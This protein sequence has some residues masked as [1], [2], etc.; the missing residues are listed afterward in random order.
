M[1]SLLSSQGGVDRKSHFEWHI[2]PVLNPDG[3]VYTWT[4]DRMWRKNR[5]LGQKISTLGLEKYFFRQPTPSSS[6]VGTDL[7]RNFPLGWEHGEEYPESDTFRGPRPFSALEVLW[8]AKEEKNILE[9]S[10]MSV[11]SH[12]LLKLT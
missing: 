1:R 2:V 5:F 9:E 12:K 4:K 6:H 7:D 10:C 11:S 8:Q 3:Y